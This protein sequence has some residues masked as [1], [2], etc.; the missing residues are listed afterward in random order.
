[1]ELRHLRYFIAVAEAGTFTLAAERLGIQQPPLSQQI[2][3]LEQELG[4][5]LFERVPKG[6]KL[7]V[8]GQVFVDEARTI[9][10]SVDRA[11][12]RAGSAAH[13]LTGKLSL[14]FTSSAVTHW[15]APRMISGFRQAYP[16]VEL[17]YQEGSAAKLTQAVAKGSLD[18]GAVR[19]PVAHPQGVA[20]HTLVNEQ[21]LLV[22]PATHPLVKNAKK[23]GAPEKGKGAEGERNR[24]AGDKLATLSLRALKDEPFILTRRPGAP[25]MYAD[26][27][28]ACHRAGFTP[29]IAAE[30][31]NMLTNV[32]LVAAGVGVSAVPESMRNVHAN[33]VV[34]FHPKEGAELAA[35]LTIVYLAAVPNP[36]VR[37]FLSFVKGIGTLP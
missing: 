34:Y 30:V 25:G 31:E 13:G 6:V 36:A 21:M 35:P 3:A 8:G 32:A 9:L 33:D 23:A 17:E 11:S 18:I 14:G 16:A 28:S 15:L 37:S 7:T 22:L 26:L 4:F 12:Q 19:K 20:F 27:I 10:A 5:A 1:M 29:K 2:K 24:R